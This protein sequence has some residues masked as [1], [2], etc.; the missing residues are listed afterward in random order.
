MFRIFLLYNQTL[1]QN[2][3]ELIHAS[4]S[5]KLY[6]CQFTY[7]FILGHWSHKSRIRAIYRGKLFHIPTTWGSWLLNVITQCRSAMKFLFPQN[8]TIARA[9]LNW[10]YSPASGSKLV[11]WV[12]E[13]FVCDDDEGFMLEQLPGYCLACSFQGNNNSCPNSRTETLFEGTKVK[14]WWTRDQLYDEIEKS[15]TRLGSNIH[16]FRT[17]LHMVHK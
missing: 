14:V 16:D 10:R 17:I 2:L 5:N 3:N 4:L 7:L 12:M 11:F 8:T 9:V 1:K 15:K 6:V 13:V